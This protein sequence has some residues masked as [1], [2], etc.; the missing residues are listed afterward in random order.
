VRIATEL[1]LVWNLF[2]LIGFQHSA[3]TRITGQG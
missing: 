2:A 1:P 3:R